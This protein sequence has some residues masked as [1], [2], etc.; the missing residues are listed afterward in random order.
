MCEIKKEELL[1]ELELLMMIPNFKRSIYHKI[2]E[3]K[4]ILRE[5]VERFHEILTMLDEIEPI[6]LTRE[7]KFSIEK[8]GRQWVPSIPGIPERIIDFIVNQNPK[9]GLITMLKNAE[10][11]GISYTINFERTGTGIIN[12][13]SIRGDRHE[14][15]NQAPPLNPEI[16]GE[17]KLLFQYIF[18]NESLCK[19]VISEFYSKWKPLVDNDCIPLTSAK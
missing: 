12:V 1:K 11:D 4:A 2:E 16:M 19:T 14:K 3:L 10:I 8:M 9:P 7:R 13:L 17:V 18:D 6:D 5:D 15:R